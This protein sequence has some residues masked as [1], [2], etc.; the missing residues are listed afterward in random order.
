MVADKGVSGIELLE[1]GHETGRDLTRALEDAEQVADR[2]L[3]FFNIGAACRGQKGTRG[4][5]TFVRVHELNNVHT[6]GH[7][8]V[9]RFPFENGSQ[10]LANQRRGSRGIVVGEKVQAVF[11]VFETQSESNTDTKG[12]VII[13][14]QCGQVVEDDSFRPDKGSHA[15][16]SRSTRIAT[17]CGAHASC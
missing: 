10:F 15:G 5:K 16:A 1:F 13:G 3:P 12:A 6:F 9:F 17:F 2:S 4:S 8:H 7:A 14:V 11:N